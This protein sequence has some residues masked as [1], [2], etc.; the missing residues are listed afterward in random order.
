[1]MQRR[2]RAA[3]LGRDGCICR[4]RRLSLTFVL[5]CGG[6]LCRR[7]L[8][9]SQLGGLF[10]FDLLS[11]CI[12]GLSQHFCIVK[13]LI[14][15][16]LQLLP[17]VTQ[18][19]PSN[20]LSPQVARKIIYVRV[21]GGSLRMTCFEGM[22]VSLV[23][24]ELALGSAQAIGAGTEQ[25]VFRVLQIILIKLKLHKCEIELLLSRVSTSTFGGGN[26]S[27]QL[28]DSVLVSLDRGLRFARTRLKLSNLRRRW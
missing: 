18:G 25:V 27:F 14:A 23:P 12:V 16:W 22:L 21:I 20:K 13:G 10:G 26:L 8:L 11:Q 1:M 3:G 24:V 17:L 6:L 7:L 2:N 28:I 15:R 19:P 9:D 5:L 4:H